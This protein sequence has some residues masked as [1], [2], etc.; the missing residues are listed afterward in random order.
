[1][2][3]ILQYKKPIYLFIVIFMYAHLFSNNRSFNKIDKPRQFF[4]GITL[5]HR[6][7]EHG[8][9]N[10]DLKSKILSNLS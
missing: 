2:K 9:Q 8:W 1:M 6:T 5:N 3:K 4:S 7:D 10:L